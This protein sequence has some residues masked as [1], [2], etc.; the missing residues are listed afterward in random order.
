MTSLSEQ[1]RQAIDELTCLMEEEQEMHM[2]LAGSPLEDTTNPNDDYDDHKG[3]VN[4][5]GLSHFMSIPRETLPCPMDLKATVSPA[6]QLATKPQSSRANSYAHSFALLFIL[7]S[8]I[9]LL[10]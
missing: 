4:K 2:A 6:V 9:P 10:T 8:A 3:T 7:I 1:T 5:D